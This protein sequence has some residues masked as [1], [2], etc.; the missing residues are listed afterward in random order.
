[1]SKANK[2][3]NMWNIIRKS[4]NLRSVPSAISIKTFRGVIYCQ[5]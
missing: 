5:I 4:K 3:G 2:S 1:M